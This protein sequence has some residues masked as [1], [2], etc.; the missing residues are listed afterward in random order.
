MSTLQLD[1]SV[2][3]GPNDAMLLSGLLGLVSWKEP[4]FRNW[5]PFHPQAKIW[6]GLRQLELHLGVPKF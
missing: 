2:P 3:N 4:S 1:N 6:A 5:T